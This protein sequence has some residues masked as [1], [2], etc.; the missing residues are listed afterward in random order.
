M[1]G[2][3]RLGLNEKLKFVVL[4]DPLFGIKLKECS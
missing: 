3:V 1:Y 4:Y 2:I